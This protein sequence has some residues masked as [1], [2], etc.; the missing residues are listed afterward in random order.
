ML[1]YNSLP[2]SDINHSYS[3]GDLDLADPVLR[4]LASV[5]FWLGMC[6]ASVQVAILSDLMDLATLHLYCFYVYAARYNALLI[7]LPFDYWYWC[8]CDYFY[9][10]Y[11][12]VFIITRNLPYYPLVHLWTHIAKYIFF[13]VR[14]LVLLLMILLTYYLE[15]L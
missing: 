10:C 8:Y 1:L 4:S 11:I 5:F 13:S 7:G 3:F 12:H 14:L 9:Y 15:L 6:G 2:F